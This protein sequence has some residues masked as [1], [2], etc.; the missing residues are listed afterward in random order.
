MGSPTAG[1]K[2]RC[3][4]GSSGGEGADRRQSALAIFLVGQAG[5]HPV[6]PGMPS[7]FNSPFSPPYLEE[8]VRTTACE[9]DSGE[10]E[11]ERPEPSRRLDQGCPPSKSG[12]LIPGSILTGQ[13]HITLT[14]GSSR[15]S[16]HPGLRAFDVASGLRLVRGRGREDACGIPASG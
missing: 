3:A 15:V 16:H 5:Y 8:R 10:S 14:G 7:G 2:K 1:C 13:A 6:R 9:S 11:H 4:R 12:G